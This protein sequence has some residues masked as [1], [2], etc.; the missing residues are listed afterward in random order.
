MPLPGWHL[1][2]LKPTRVQSPCLHLCPVCSL[3]LEC[4][5]PAVPC[6]WIL[7]S[8]SFQ[9]E[10]ILLRE[11]L[12][13]SQ[14]PPSHQLGSSSFY[15]FVFS[16]PL[17]SSVVCFSPCSIAVLAC[18]LYRSKN[19]VC[20]VHCYVP[21]TQDTTGRI[22]RPPKYLLDQ[23]HV[24]ICITTNSTYIETLSNTELKVIAKSIIWLN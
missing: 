12:A 10:C 19:S 13:T 20:L 17:S 22:L 9:P 1:Q 8:F 15:L 14:V 5:C 7:Q 23:Q 24:P 21:D 11:I 18:K 3:L 4:S 16:Q 2:L 6:C